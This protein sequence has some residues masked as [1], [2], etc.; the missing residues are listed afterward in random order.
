MSEGDVSEGDVSESHLG[1]AAAGQAAD[2]GLVDERE[3]V[4]QS[5]R[6]LDAE[7][8]AGDL[9][10]ADYVSLRGDYVARAAQLVRATTDPGAA[11]ESEGMAPRSSRLRNGVA[12]A[13]VAL[14]AVAIG[15]LVARSSG[16]RLDGQTVTGETRPSAAGELAKARAAMSEGSAVEALKSFD[17]VLAIDPDNLEALAYRGWLLHLAG[18]GEEALVWVDKALAVDDAY[19]DAQFFRGVI[20]LRDL[21]RPADAAQSLTA[22]LDSGSVPDALRAQVEAVRAEAVEA[23]GGAGATGSPALATTAATPS[24]LAPPTTTAAVP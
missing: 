13:C 14:S 3:F 10:D 2:P 20:L 8:A 6:D 18:L 23:A 22:F 17:A 15:L 19:P 9:D 5:L 21:D 24:S 7:H 4:L 1:S 16:A 11:V 12:A